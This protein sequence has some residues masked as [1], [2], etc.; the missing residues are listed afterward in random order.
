M[1]LIMV[2]KNKVDLKERCATGQSSKAGMQSPLI[3][4]DFVPWTTQDY[5]DLNQSRKPACKGQPLTDGRPL[6]STV[7]SRLSQITMIGMS[8]KGQFQSET[9]R[10][11]SQ[12]PQGLED[13]VH[14]WGS[15][16]HTE[17][18]LNRIGK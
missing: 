4:S 15:F 12:S 16:K 14:I 1:S 17:N 6:V 9:F 8:C 18:P 2:P 5:A 7:N 3:F 10:N 13:T 11:R